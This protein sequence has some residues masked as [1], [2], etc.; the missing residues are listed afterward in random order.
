[1]FP[2]L[3]PTHKVY[4]FFFRNDP[5][6]ANLEMSTVFGDSLTRACGAKLLQS[7]ST[8]HYRHARD[9]GVIRN[10]GVTTPPHGLGRNRIS[11]AIPEEHLVL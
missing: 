4:V 5:A 10:I 9:P 6:V 11:I 7:K 8:V 3:V 1:M 2:R